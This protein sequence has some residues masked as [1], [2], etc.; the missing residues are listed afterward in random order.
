MM[1]TE[2]EERQF[3][4]LNARM[5]KHVERP[6]HVMLPIEAL[7]DIRWALAHGLCAITEIDRCHDAYEIH[8][9]SDGSPIPS[10]LRPTMTMASIDDMPRYG[11]AIL[12]LEYAKEVEAG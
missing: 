1:T 11:E 9:N 7:A 5:A 2:T 6:T 12:W 3:F 8:K 10:E 4:S